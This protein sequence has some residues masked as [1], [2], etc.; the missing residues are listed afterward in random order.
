MKLHNGH[1]YTVTNKYA[2]EYRIIGAYCLESGYIKD[3][4]SQ[5][6]I[7]LDTKEKQKDYLIKNFNII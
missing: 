1:W 6:M 3:H 4:S 7:L 2:N 5:G